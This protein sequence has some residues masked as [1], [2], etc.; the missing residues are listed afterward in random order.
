[1]D[2]GSRYKEAEPLTTKTADE[3]AKAFVKIYK[4]SKLDYPKV[5]QVDSGSEFKGAVKKLFESHGTQIRRGQ[6]NIHRMQGIVERFN[7]TLAEQIFGVQ[8]AKEILIA[9]RE[10][11]EVSKERSTEWVENLPLYI[12][13]LNNTVTRMIGLKPNDAIKLDHIFLRSKHQQKTNKKEKVL[14]LSP[15]ER[16][17][18]LYEPGELEGGQARATDPIWSLST[19]TID[20]VLSHNNQPILYYLDPTGPQRS[21]VREELMVVPLASEL[22]PDSILTS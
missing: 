3:V 12:A 6:P 20:R 5:L 17:R 15:D 8:Y 22:P 19:H 7:R 9:A 4:R 1:V 16:V 10:S 11:R 21:F 18:Y 14:E 13:N 2:V